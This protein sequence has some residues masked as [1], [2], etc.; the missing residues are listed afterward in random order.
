MSEHKRVGDL[1]LPQDA[2]FQRR[3]WAIERA[4]WVGY[5]L[6]LLAAALGVFGSGPLSSI[7]IREPNDALRVDTERFARLDADLTLRIEALVHSGST[8]ATLAF[9]EKYIRD[10]HVES[11]V[12][13][14]AEV[15]MYD[16]RCYYTFAITEPQYPTRVIFRLKPDR[17]GIVSGKLQLW[18]VLEAARH[19][20]GLERMDQVKYAIL[21]RSGE[22]SIVPKAG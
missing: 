22:I 4:A 16:G 20:H 1:E 18:D 21:E 13:E 3:S 2:R 19:L 17:A 6:L 10:M 9:D 15:Q 8:T 5:A 12:P 7:H 11:V 14:P